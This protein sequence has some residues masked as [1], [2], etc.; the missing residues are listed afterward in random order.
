LRALLES[1]EFPL[2]SGCIA[3]GQDLQVEHRSELGLDWLLDGFAAQI[4][5]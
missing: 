2:M 3:G 5:R 4:G 1:G